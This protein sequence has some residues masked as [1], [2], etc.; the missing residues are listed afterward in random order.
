MPVM[1]ALIMLIMLIMGHRNAIGAMLWLWSH[2]GVRHAQCKFVEFVAKLDRK[3]QEIEKNPRS[4]KVREKV[5][6]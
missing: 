3:G 4:L 2:C 1:H 5:V 6:G